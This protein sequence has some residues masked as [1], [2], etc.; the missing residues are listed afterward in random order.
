MTFGGLESG[1]PPKRD[2]GARPEPRTKVRKTGSG[3]RY[4]VWGAPALQTLP[5]RN[6]R[7]EPPSGDRKKKEQTINS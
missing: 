1:G 6:I 4:P 5:L 3:R 2:P 7:I